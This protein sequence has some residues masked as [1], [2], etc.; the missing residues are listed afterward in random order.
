MTDL[1]ALLTPI[2]LADSLSVV[3]MCIVPLAILLAGRQPL[4]GSA[5]FLSGVAIPYYAFGVF[6]ALGLDRVFGQLEEWL[7]KEPGT[8][9]LILQLVIGAVVLFFG[10]KM[11]AAREERKRRAADDA[12]EGMTPWKGFALGAGFTIAGA[13]GALP[14]FA[15]ID[16]ILRADLTTTEALLALGYYNVVFISIPVVLVVLRLTLGKRASGLFDRVREVAEKWGRR[17]VIAVLMLIGLFLVVD[18]VGW[19]F[20]RPLIRFD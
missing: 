4:L 10:W 2:S 12:S 14:Y 3:P 7:K 20:D 15:A 13:W 9:D 8:L 6:I 19:F 5:M 16:Q 18:G 11:V 1:L 17:F